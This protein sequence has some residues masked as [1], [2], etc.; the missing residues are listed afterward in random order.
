LRHRRGCEKRQNVAE[1]AKIFI[2]SD[3]GIIVIAGEN[4]S[5]KTNRA[6]RSMP[7]RAEIYSLIEFC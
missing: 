5:C 7:L 4:N 3:D 2:I 6:T 1:S